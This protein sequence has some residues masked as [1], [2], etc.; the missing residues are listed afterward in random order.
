MIKQHRLDPFQRRHRSDRFGYSSRVVFL[1]RMVDP[2]EYSADQADPWFPGIDDYLDAYHRVGAPWLW[3]DRLAMG[4][5]RIERDLMDPR[6]R[7]WRIDEGHRLAG[8][9]ELIARSPAE[10]EI[11]HCGLISAARGRG[12][13]QRLINSALAGA[14][15]LGARRVWL[16][17]CS[18]DSEA[19]LG[20]YQRA[21][22]RIF[23][24]RLE[25]V[26]DPRRRG[27]LDATAGN[28]VDLPWTGQQAVNAFSAAAD[29]GS[30]AAQAIEN[31]SG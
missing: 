29:G 28:A 19:A 12:L 18:E 21:G 23:A 20:F 7:C 6:Q 1:E 17:T 22:F 27:L 25:W 9:C 24:T 26:I 5:D 31:R 13:G 14:H 11:L 10:A 2:A 8:F 30:G 4:R 16:H 3:S 15:A